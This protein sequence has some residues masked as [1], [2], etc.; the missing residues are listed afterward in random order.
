MNKV[1]NRSG[2]LAWL[3]SARGEH[4]PIRHCCRRCAISVGDLARG[5]C[6]EVRCLGKSGSPE[7]RKYCVFN[8]VNRYGREIMGYRK[9]GANDSPSILYSQNGSSLSAVARKLSLALNNFDHA[10]L[11][12]LRTSGPYHDQRLRIPT[13]TVYFAPIAR[14]IKNEA[15]SLWTS[16]SR[17]PRNN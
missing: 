2:R 13:V 11:P 12:D 1:A 3:S 8:C 15:H 6:V 5:E 17:T 16:W 4:V 14:T 7:V 9:A 10:R